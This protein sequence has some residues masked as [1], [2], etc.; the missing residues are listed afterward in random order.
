VKRERRCFRWIAHT[1]FDQAG[2]HGPDSVS[3]MEQEWKEF[4][5]VIESPPITELDQVTELECRNV[6]AG[7][8]TTLL[9]VIKRSNE[10]AALKKAR[11]LTGYE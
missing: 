1:V 2:V 3:A 11:G 7:N 10:I 9:W 8:P 6:S 5:D 4:L